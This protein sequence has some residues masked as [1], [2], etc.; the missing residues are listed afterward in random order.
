MISLVKNFFS[1]QAVKEKSFYQCNF[2]IFKIFFSIFV[3]KL[4][5]KLYKKVL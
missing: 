5:S 1:K 2:F 3:L 4:S